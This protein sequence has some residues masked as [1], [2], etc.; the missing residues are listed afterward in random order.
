MCKVSPEGKEK[1]RGH[2]RRERAKACHAQLSHTYWLKRE[3]RGIVSVL[4]QFLGESSPDA[5]FSSNIKFT[6]VHVY[7]HTRTHRVTPTQGCTPRRD[8]YRHKDSHSTIRESHNSAGTGEHRPALV[9]LS[10]ALP[11]ES[12]WSSLL[13]DLG[14]ASVEV[15]RCQ[16]LCLDKQ[17]A[18]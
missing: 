6:H 17:G 4:R 18:C 16:R 13:E 8:M 3:G 5:T 2:R 10:V 12:L 14:R 15:R 7:L 9:A 1:K 11:V